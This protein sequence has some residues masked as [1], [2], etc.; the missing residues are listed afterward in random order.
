MIMSTWPGKNL[1]QKH[2]EELLP[3]V[4]QYLYENREHRKLVERRADFQRR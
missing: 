2:E 1:K 3:E 4:L